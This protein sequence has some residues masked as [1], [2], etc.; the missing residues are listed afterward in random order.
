M[1]LTRL[2]AR[3]PSC[4]GIVVPRNAIDYN[5]IGIIGLY[6]WLWDRS[7][8]GWLDG[9]P[10]DLQLRDDSDRRANDVLGHSRNW[11]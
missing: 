7:A 1:E 11:G 9:D 2:I 10:S 6:E 5:T 3:Q 8:L 4:L